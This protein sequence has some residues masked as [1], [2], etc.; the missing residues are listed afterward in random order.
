MI[1]PKTISEKLAG[2]K[3]LPFLLAGFGFIYF[4]GQLWMAGQTQLSVLDEGLYLYKGLLFATGK[5][6]P[7][8]DFGPWTNQ[9]P[10]AFLLPGWVQQ[11]FGSGL[12][13]GRLF[14]FVLGLF[15]FLGLWA[16]SHRLGNRW[17]GAVVVLLFAINPATNKIYSVSTSQGLTS[18]LLIACL[19]FLLG[20]D[21][22]DWQVFIGGVLAGLIVMVRINM[23]PLLPITLFYIYWEKGWRSVL[24]CLAGIAVFFGGGHIAY[25][26]EILKIWAKWL[27]FPFLKEWFPPST[28]P[29]WNPDN[30]IGF[31]V[32]SFFLA[33]RF[34]FAALLGSI[35]SLTLLGKARLDQ[36]RT[37][38]PVVFLMV[39]LVVFFLVHV[40]ASLF[41]DY[42]VFCFPTYTAFYSVLGLLIIAISLPSWKIPDKPLAPLAGLTITAILLLGITYSAEDSYLLLLGEDVYKD[43]LNLKLSFLGKVQLW[44]VLANK[45][46]LDK[47]DILKLFHT[48]LPVAMIFLVLGFSI[49]IT[50]WVIKFRKH[51]ASKAFSFL[52][53]TLYLVGCIASPSPLFSGYY[54]AYDCD[55]NVVEVTEKTGRE[56][57]AIIP[58]GS[59]LYWAGYSPVTLTYLPNVI[60]HPAQLH[61]G[62][63]YRISQDD[64]ALEQYGWWN[65][66]LATKWLAQ[67]DYLLAQGNNIEKVDQLTNTSAMYEMIYTSEPQSCQPSTALHLYRRK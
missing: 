28:I 25:W 53:L 51:T 15:T 16:T 19:W 67:A 7:F 32:A 50:L 13:T 23:L 29:T 30:P 12:R 4:A 66:S 55:A 2:N 39:L 64:V 9:M 8:Q 26:P 18:F 14:A 46:S 45:Y 58:A 57:S 42:C 17:A 21:R 20:K 36:S 31:R 35:V 65:E 41:N 6:A 34:H 24:W 27:P 48:W 59:T 54:N 63:S 3:T 62:Y 61:G 56:L 11:I 33:F 47:I 52:L 1:L 40:W 10:F 60:I 44:Q 5:F 49:L 22:R 37:T 43:L 38:K